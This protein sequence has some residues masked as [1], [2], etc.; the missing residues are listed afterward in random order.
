MARYW[1]FLLV[2]LPL[3]TPAHAERTGNEFLRACKDVVAE[4]QTPD[5]GFCIGTIAAMRSVGRYLPALMRS[6]VP[7]EAEDEQVVRAVIQKLEQVP[8]ILDRPYL[9]LV[10]YDLRAAWPCP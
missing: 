7:L 9:T 2:L 3:A 4:R 5:A 1:K 8:Q 6:C 10:P